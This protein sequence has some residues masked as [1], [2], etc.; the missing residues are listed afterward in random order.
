MPG[1]RSDDLQR[2]IEHT[3]R[4][5]LHHAVEMTERAGALETRAA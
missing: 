5:Q 3:L 2:M 4:L 1:R